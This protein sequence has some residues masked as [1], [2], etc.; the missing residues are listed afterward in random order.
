MIIGNNDEYVYIN[1]ANAPHDIH[2]IPN[3]PND[4]KVGEYYIIGNMV[5][6]FEGELSELNET[7]LPEGS[8]GMFHS[9]FYV[10]TI[11]KNS[12]LYNDRST[13][14]I[15]S[16]SD[17]ER[18][19]TDVD[20][21]LQRY[22][23]NYNSGNNLARNVENKLK[24]TGDVYVPQ[25]K[26]T[27]DV[28]TRMMKLM[29]IDK[30]VI[31]SNYKDKCNGQKDYNIDNLRSALNGTTVNMT[32]TKFLSWCKLLGLEWKFE[33]CDDPDIEN[34]R[35]PLI[36]PVSISWDQDLTFD[37]GPLEPGIFKVP[38]SEKDDPLKKLVKYAVWKK[39]MVLVEYRDKG[40]TPHLINNMRSA[41]KRGSKMMIT[42]F[43]FWCEL[44]NITYNFTLYDPETGITHYGNKYYK[45]K[46]YVEEEDE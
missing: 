18:D 33:I 27:D 10:N 37:V 45:A 17:Y 46:D 22:I 41:L 24:N 13:S 36:E 29:I 21:I 16:R 43:V 28:L 26:D 8:M 3:D 40:S 11:S 14:R 25:I 15:S 32:V 19:M 2:D 6:L 35:Y 31:L 12:E 5:Y 38:V 9:R 44:L 30:G 4:M 1:S 7:T 42:Y 20:S 34:P 39:K 23:S